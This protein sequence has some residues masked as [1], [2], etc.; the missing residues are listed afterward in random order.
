M[1]LFHNRRLCLQRKLRLL[2][3]EPH[4]RYR[5][6]KNMSVNFSLTNLSNR[7]YLDPMSNV[8]AP[9]PGRTFSIGIQGKF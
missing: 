4:I 3:F 2:A 6:G 8:P 1:Q 7:Y 5:F 9:G